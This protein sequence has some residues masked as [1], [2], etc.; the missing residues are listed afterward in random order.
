MQTPVF[1]ICSRSETQH[2]ERGWSIFPRQCH[3]LQRKRVFQFWF[4]KSKKEQPWQAALKFAPFRR[5]PQQQYPLTIIYSQQVI[6][7]PNTPFKMCNTFFYQHWVLNPVSPLS[8]QRPAFSK[9]L[10]RLR[11]A[12]GQSKPEIQ[13]G[14]FLPCITVKC[15]RTQLVSLLIC[16]RAEDSVF[17]PSALR[18]SPLKNHPIDQMFLR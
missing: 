9:R 2:P 3:Y 1:S 17:H 18:L 5:K 16:V 10:A 11:N 7:L 15:G 14:L 12:Q 8:G 13:A 4:Q 6:L